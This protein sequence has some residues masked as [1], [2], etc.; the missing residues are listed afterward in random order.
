MIIQNKMDKTTANNICII[1]LIFLFQKIEQ[2]I[3][4]PR[5]L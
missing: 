2:G 4:I 5:I 1:I 3:D